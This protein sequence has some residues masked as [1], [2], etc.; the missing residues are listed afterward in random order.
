MNKKKLIFI[1]TANSCRSQIA[2]GFLK[3][4]A[5]DIF[6][7]FSAGSH[8]S[9][10]HPMSIE[11]MREIGIDISSY[12]SEPMLKYLNIGID[13]VVTVCDDA[14]VAC[15]AF[16]GNVKRLHWS[17]KDPVK[18]IEHIEDFRNA[19]DEIKKRVIDL[20]NELSETI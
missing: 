10:V 17:I 6:D 2:E 8:P 14:R 19:R 1:C 12:R 16:P 9:I 4:I 7:V 3:E 13:I 15:P 20:K 18:K 5:S 11:V